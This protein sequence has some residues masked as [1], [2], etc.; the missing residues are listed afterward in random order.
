ML[1]EEANAAVHETRHRYVVGP[2]VSVALRAQAA[3]NKASSIKCL[4][5]RRYTP[6]GVRY[7]GTFVDEE[8]TGALFG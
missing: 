3:A 5:P 1:L 6:P 7:S 8:D 2:K 4:K